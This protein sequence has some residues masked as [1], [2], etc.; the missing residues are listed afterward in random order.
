MDGKTFNFEQLAPK[1]IR[2]LFN[3]ENFTDLTLVTNDNRQIKCHKVILSSSS[4]FFNNVL[5][6]NPHPNPLIYLKDITYKKL[7]LI[8]NFIYL[9]ECEVP[10]VEVNDFIHVAKA[11]LVEG[12]QEKVQTTEYEYSEGSQKQHYP[13]T[14]TN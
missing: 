8:I 12:L 4:G 9:R 3:D 10:V 1:I 11:L 7:Q 6:Q 5:T 14:R 2:N 13:N